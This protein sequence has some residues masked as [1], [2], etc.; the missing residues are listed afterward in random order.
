MSGADFWADMATPEPAA[1]RDVLAELAPA[2]APTR[3]AA[4]PVA[5]W[6]KDRGFIAPMDAHL[7][8]RSVEAGPDDPPHKNW[9]AEDLRV[10]SGKAINAIERRGLAKD[11]NTDIPLIRLG[12]ETA[13]EG[14]RDF[15]S[16][17]GLPP[18]QMAAACAEIAKVEGME[19]WADQGRRYE[20]ARKK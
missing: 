17:W 2:R 19:G 5:T 7:V 16:A 14:W 10:V 6:P 8:F 9:L 13:A 12:A 4:P 15:L 20:E 18:E 3:A 1:P 11:W